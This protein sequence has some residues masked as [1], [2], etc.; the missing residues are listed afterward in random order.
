MRDDGPLPEDLERFSSDTAICPECGAEVWD[1]ADVCPSC[2]AYIGG[3]ASSRHPVERW[4][5]R[6]WMVLV[7][8]ALL[9][10]MMMVYVI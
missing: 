5:R 2:Y 8:I 3:S 9:V 6:R 1:Q 4:W 10:A 7:V